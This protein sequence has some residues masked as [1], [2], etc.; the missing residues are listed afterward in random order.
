MTRI[1]L[2]R[3]RDEPN[4]RA[5]EREFKRKLKKVAGHIGEL[6]SSFDLAANP[7]NAREVEQMMADYAKALRSWAGNVARRMVSAADVKD[8]AFWEYVSREM[9]RGLRET[10]QRADMQ[11][12]KDQL[13]REQVAL[14]TSL[15]TEAAKRVNKLTERGLVS[16]TRADEIAKEIG[17]T[18]E[19]TKSRAALIART[20][21]ARTASTLTQGRAESVGSTHYVWRAVMDGDTRYGH[22]QM[23]G[24]TFE[25]ANPPRVNDGSKEY[26]HWE[27]H[28][29]GRSFNCRCWPRPVL[30][31]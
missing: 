23:N 9:S 16:G 27:Q 25:W 14:I 26:P 29:P 13:V 4:T 20:E 3:R 24:K 7:E 31:E 1:T 6:V 15:P 18:G 2:D 19:V 28:G 17:R 21:V 8:K 12:Y 22:Q 30:P 10:L 11:P 5:V